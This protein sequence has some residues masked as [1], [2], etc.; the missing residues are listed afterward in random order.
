MFEAFGAGDESADKLG[1]AANV[2]VVQILALVG[3]VGG[4][5]G[6]GMNVKEAAVDVEGFS[7]VAGDEVDDEIVHHIGQ[8]LFVLEDL[9]FSVQGVNSGFGLGVPLGAAALE[10]EMFIETE[11]GGSE[12]ELAPFADGGGD[13]AGLF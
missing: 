6:F 13:V 7:T 8:L 2:V 12:G 5:K 1:H 10:S 9:L 4:K 3:A 11:L